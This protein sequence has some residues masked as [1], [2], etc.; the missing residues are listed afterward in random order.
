M[1]IFGAQ[2]LVSS[3]DN[4]ATKT[5]EIKLV[6]YFSFSSSVLEF[7]GVTT[8]SAVDK[9]AVDHLADAVSGT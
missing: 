5:R 2:I 9:L 7:S 3:F 8:D 4:L 6:N 1:L